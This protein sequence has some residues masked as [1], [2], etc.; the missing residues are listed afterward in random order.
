M[1]RAQVAC[2]DESRGALSPSVGYQRARTKLRN[3]RNAAH[4][5]RTWLPVVVTSLQETAC[6]AQVR[7]ISRHSQRRK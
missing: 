1:C 3:W 7:A 5:S 4:R 2:T 6:R